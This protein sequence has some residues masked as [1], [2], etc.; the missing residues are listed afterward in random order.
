MS[1]RR[2]EIDE[3]R[4]ELRRLRREVSQRIIKPPKGSAGSLTRRIAIT[5]GNT[6]ATGQDGILYE[7]SEITS[8]PSAYDPSVDTTFIDGIGRGIYYLNGVSQG[9]VLVVNDGRSG[10]VINFDLLGGDDYDVGDVATTVSIEVSGGGGTTVT[11]YVIG[12]I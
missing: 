1:Q 7:S 12:F 9:Y 4:A 2:S 8:V 5:G 10:S 3:L 6:L 11:A